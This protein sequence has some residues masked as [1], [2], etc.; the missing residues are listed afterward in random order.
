MCDQV[1][2]HV[3]RRASVNIPW[4]SRQAGQQVDS[5]QVQ[6]GPRPAQQSCVQQHMLRS[7]KCT[8]A[9]H[10]AMA[11]TPNA[12]A[13]KLTGHG[14]VTGPTLLSRDIA[15]PSMMMVP[16]RIQIPPTKKLI[17]QVGR[18][19]RWLNLTCIPAPTHQTP[20]SRETAARAPSAAP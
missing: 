15:A 14:R 7:R 16:M 11:C 3:N 13:C 8:R 2:V 19:F 9:Q 20:L 12:N 6:P 18:H 10:M 17:L 5:R 1:T 4:V